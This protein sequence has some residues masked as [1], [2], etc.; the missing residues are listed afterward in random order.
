MF[1]DLDE[2]ESEEEKKEEVKEEEKVVDDPKKQFKEGAE[3]LATLLTTKQAVDSM[4][5]DSF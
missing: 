5:L 1:D 2:S 3:A 4:G